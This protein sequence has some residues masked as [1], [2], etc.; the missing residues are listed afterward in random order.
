VA[1]LLEAISKIVDRAQEQGVGR[2]KSAA[3]T[4]SM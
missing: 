3:Y 1:K 2:R 4:G